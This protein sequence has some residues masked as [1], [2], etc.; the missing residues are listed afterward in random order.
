MLAPLASSSSPCDPMFMVIVSFYNST[1]ALTGSSCHPT[2]LGASSATAI[3]RS[4]VRDSQDNVSGVSQ[5]LDHE[6]RHGGVDQRLTGSA[7][8]LVVVSQTPVVGEPREGAL[9]HPTARQLL[10]GRP[11]RQL[12]GVHL[13]PLPEPLPRPDP[14]DLLRRRLRGVVD[15]LDLQA[16]R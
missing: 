16:E 14:Q 6:P 4:M 2:K 3:R 7:K 1:P 5:P 10:E 8:P 11:L 12:A 9:G 13:S 15:H